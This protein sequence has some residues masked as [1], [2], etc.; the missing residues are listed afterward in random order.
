ML[1]TIN[2][3]ICTMLGFS[4]IG[5]VEI[6]NQNSLGGDIRMTSPPLV[7]GENGNYYLLTSTSASGE[8]GNLDVSEYDGTYLILVKYNESNEIVWQK[9]YYGSES[10]VSTS[11]LFK[12]SSVYLL[13]YSNSPISG[14]KSAE[15]YGGK[16]YWL[17]K[18]DT[19][20]EIIWQKTYGGDNRELPSNMNFLDD[21]NILLSG[22]SNSGISGVKSEPAIGTRDLWIVKVAD[23]DGEI[24]WDKTIGSLGQE[25]SS[26]LAETDEGNIIISS[27][28]DGDVGGDKTEPKYGNLDVWIVSLDKDGN[29]IWDKTVGGLGF[30]LSGHFV[31]KDD[32]IYLFAQSESSIGGARIVPLKGSMDIWM[33][34][35]SIEDGSIINQFSYGGNKNE[36]I[37]SVSYLRDDLIFLSA[38]SDSD[39]SGDKDE[40]GR[41]QLDYWPI[42]INEDG[43]LLWQTTIGGSNDDVLQ[44]ILERPNNKLLLAG[45]SKSRVS[46]D[47]TATYYGSLTGEDVWLVEIDATILSTDE[48]EI[49]LVNVDVYPN[50]F[51]DELHLKMEQPNKIEKVIIRDIQGKLVWESSIKDQNQTILTLPTP[52]FESGTYLI[53]VTGEGFSMLKRVVKL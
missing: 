43:N 35:L 31:L 48:A 17:L 44:N 38:S 16:D 5:Q 24:I 39:I 6:T 18:V 49:E 9:S 19:D 1:K 42:L 20:G 41:G 8:S 34:T 12:D 51:V 3:I 11:I 10:D 27:L 47:R 26:S 52:N 2:L 30:E 29:K 15:N 32:L 50:P 37:Y 22:V 28:S 33:L 53:N 21:G 23:T 14:N 45:L 7:N 25:Y 40:E 36:R 13:S 4:G 46:G